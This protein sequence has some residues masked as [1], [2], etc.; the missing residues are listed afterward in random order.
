MISA[1]VL[2]ANQS[3]KLL[4]LLIASATEP[5]SGRRFFGARPYQTINAHSAP[6]EVPLKPTSSNLFRASISFRTSVRTPTS[7]AACVPPPWQAMATFGAKSTIVRPPSLSG[8][9]CELPQLL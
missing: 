9:P 8:A 1:G 4:M 6:A 7:K 2:A 3:Q 5:L